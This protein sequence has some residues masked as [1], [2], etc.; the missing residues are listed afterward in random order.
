[1]NDRTVDILRELLRAEE[2]SLVPRALESVVFISTLSVV[3][4]TKIQRITR[5]CEEH[6]AWLSEMILESGGAPAPRVGNTSSA[7]LHFQALDRMLPRIMADHERLLNLHRKA[8][9]LL[10]EQPRATAVIER[11]IVR[12]Q[13]HVATFG[14]L[15]NDGAALSPAQ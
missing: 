12:L 15:I 6:Q 10:V 13:E 4:G 5:Q 7:D 11:I 1:M 14:S 8:A 3:H 9:G 2:A